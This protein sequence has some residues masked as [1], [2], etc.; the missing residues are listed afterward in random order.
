[1]QAK[2]IKLSHVVIWKLICCPLSIEQQFAL[3]GKR[4]A[5]KKKINISA[6]VLLITT[7]IIILIETTRLLKDK[8]IMQF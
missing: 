7:I 1:M 8:K 5:N 4:F 2:K 3:L 6:Y